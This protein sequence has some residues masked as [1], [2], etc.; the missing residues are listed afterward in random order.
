MLVGG[1]FQSLSRPDGRTLRR[2]AL[3]S[4]HTHIVFGQ[5]TF[6][7]PDREP[8]ELSFDPHGNVTHVEIRP[9]RW[10]Y[11]IMWHGMLFFLLCMSF[12]SSLVRYQFCIKILV[13]QS[14]SNTAYL[15][16]RADICKINT[17]IL[18]SFKCNFNL[19]YLSFAM[20]ESRMCTP[21]ISGWNLY[22]MILKSAC[23]YSNSGRC[24]TQL[25]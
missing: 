12:L 17:C 25:N 5:E 22:M 19:N 11:E 15:L 21:A 3:H 9:Q 13:T 4:G 7:L 20:L 18:P 24:K 10:W 1:C 8:R 16:I 6:P 2:V 23:N 14:E